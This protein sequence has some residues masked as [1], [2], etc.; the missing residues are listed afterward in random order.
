MATVPDCHWTSIL[1][2]NLHPL[3]RALL[4]A[5][6]EISMGLRKYNIIADPSLIYTQLGFTQY[7]FEK[8]FLKNHPY[9]IRLRNHH[10][11]VIFETLEEAMSFDPAMAGSL[12]I[13]RLAG[14]GSPK[15]SSTQKRSPESIS[16]GQSSKP[17]K[18]VPLIGG[19]WTVAVRNFIAK[20]AGADIPVLILG[21]SGT[22]KE[23]VARKIHAE[24][25]RCQGPF[26][27]VNCAAIPSELLE[28]ELFGHERGSFTGAER[29]KPGKFELAENG[30][31]FLDEIGEMP[32]RLQAKLLGVL[33]ENGEFNRVGG[34]HVLHTN[35]RVITA[36]NCDL[37]FMVQSR[38]FRED[39]Y[40]RIDVL[41]ITLPPLCERKEDI[42]D[43][44]RYMLNFLG[45]SHYD[46]DPEAMRM[47]MCYHWPGNVR[48]LQN[49]LQ[50]ALVLAHEPILTIKDFPVFNIVESSADAKIGVKVTI[51]ILTPGEPSRPLSLKEIS[52]RVVI[53]AERVQI[54]RVLTMTR[55]NRMKA[56]KLLKISYRAL[57]YKIKNCG[58]QLPEDTSETAVRVSPVPPQPRSITDIPEKTIRQFDQV[59][60]NRKE[61][62]K[63]LDTP[64]LGSVGQ[65]IRFHSLT[66][67]E[68]K[69]MREKLQELGGDTIKLAGLM[70]LSPNAL[71]IKLKSRHII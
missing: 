59:N 33:Q 53:D 10:F 28:S 50:H 37:H 55:W 7:R 67:A 49:A 26:L 38:R 3:F 68:T 9:L 61:I 64:S 32:L 43:L 71:K 66:D 45:K 41:S 42:P 56:A 2:L 5:A 17:I 18:D 54:E 52:R 34:R 31:I 1:P 46:V 16:A 62:A 14:L 57:L 24:S 36:T 22:G 70:G 58:L 30:T 4:A 27:K 35:A 47:L 8:I 12:M 11:F 65:F 44:V 19:E 39:L 63:I 29:Q 48:E 23:V 60:W 40:Y 69:W 25:R 15:S 6:Q 21:R 13:D 20:A 51:P